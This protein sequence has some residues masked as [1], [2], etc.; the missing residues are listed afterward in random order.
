MYSLWTGTSLNSKKQHSLGERRHHG[1]KDQ[2]PSPEPVTYALMQSFSHVSYG[3]GHT[4][5]S[6]IAAYVPVKGV[7]NRW[8][9]NTRD[10]EAGSCM[11]DGSRLGCQ[12]IFPCRLSPKLCCFLRVQT[13][14]TSSQRIHY[15]RDRRGSY[16]IH[17]RLAGRLPSSM[18]VR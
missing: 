2:Q 16:T 11:L 14:S 9:L 3:I 12:S 1:K 5:S 17:L 6:H 4:P 18:Q 7:S 10:L 13:V 15:T 8:Q